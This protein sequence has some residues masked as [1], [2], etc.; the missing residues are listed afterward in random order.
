MTNF[1]LV[2]SI[3][4]RT[5]SYKLDQYFIAIGS[6]NVI[7]HCSLLLLFGRRLATLEL[8]QCLLFCVHLSDVFFHLM[9]V[10][11]TTIRSFLVSCINISFHFWVAFQWCVSK[12]F[13]HMRMSSVSQFIILIWML[14]MTFHPTEAKISSYDGIFITYINIKIIDIIMFS[15]IYIKYVETSRDD[16][17][18]DNF[19]SRK[20][21]I[22]NQAL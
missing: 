4:E 9:Y 20:R 8:W 12:A 22:T 13:T 19:Y 16:N 15:Y 17:V 7:W 10:W 2:K 21:N 18:S 11:R 6:L 5:S 3:Y 1:L 14:N